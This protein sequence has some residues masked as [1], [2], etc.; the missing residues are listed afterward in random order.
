MARRQRREHHVADQLE[1]V[2][3]LRRGLYDDS[4]RGLLDMSSSP[5]DVV[6]RS[7]SG[8]FNWACVEQRVRI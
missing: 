7:Q 6:M 4:A 8:Q 2:L 5:N 3:M 1:G